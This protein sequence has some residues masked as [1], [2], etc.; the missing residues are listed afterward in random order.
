[1]IEIKTISQEA[2]DSRQKIVITVDSKSRDLVDTYICSVEMLTQAFCAHL[3]TLPA[4]TIASIVALMEP[5]LL[6]LTE[7]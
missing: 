3:H 2:E 1:M 6:P 7:N 4:D 5:K